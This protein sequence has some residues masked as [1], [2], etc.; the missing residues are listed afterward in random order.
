MSPRFVRS[1]KSPSWIDRLLGLAPQPVPPHAFAVEP[2]RLR[3]VL[4]GR[5]GG[6]GAASQALGASRGVDEYHEEP[7]ASE[8][9][10]KS[11]LGGPVRDNDGLRA[12]VERLVGRI[13]TPV[14]HAS[15]VVP[16]SWFRLV[17]TEVSELP[18]VADRRDEVLRWKLRR[19]VP[20][21]LDEIRLGHLEV[22][23]IANQEEPVRVLL[24]FGAEA[25]LT[26]LEE[27][28]AAAGVTL[29]QIAQPAL[30]ALAAARPSLGDGVTALLQ[31]EGHGTTLVAARDGI[32]LLHRHRAARLG[33]PAPAPDEL[34]LRELRLVR[35]YLAD[36]L[37]EQPLRRVLLVAPEGAE[38]S[39]QL[40]VREALEAPVEVATREN[41]GLRQGGPP[42]P[43][44]DL[45]PLIGAASEVFT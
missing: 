31:V 9:F 14:R 23:A 36:H 26:Q 37:P 24:G 29:G 13:A 34:A 1:T 20:F 44:R 7:L 38:S 5:G 30:A 2:E 6:R 32:P 45:L 28:F 39:W 4:V 18:R 10:A 43:W 3:Y 19:L 21:R 15:L 25:L 40:A 8:L 35:T 22:Q 33:D 41:L 17:F 27:A 12:A 42:V 16:E 11:A